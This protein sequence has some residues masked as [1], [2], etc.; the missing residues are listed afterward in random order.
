MYLGLYVYNYVSGIICISGIN[1][2]GPPTTIVLLSFMIE[3]SLI[4]C[5][6][7]TYNYICRT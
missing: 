2:K 6:V 4:M 3:L 5:E 1:L 7:Y